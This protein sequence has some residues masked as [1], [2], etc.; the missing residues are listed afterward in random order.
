MY[1]LDSTS[2]LEHPMAQ[3]VEVLRR[4]PEGLVAQFG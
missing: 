4:N 2:S 1:I 3:L